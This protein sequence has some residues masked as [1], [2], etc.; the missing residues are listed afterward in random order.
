MS[1]KRIIG[2]KAFVI[3]WSSSAISISG[4]IIFTIAISW[5]VI[6]LTK[7]ILWVSLLL[8]ATL[9]PYAFLLPF[10]GTVVDRKNKKRVVLYSYISQGIIVLTVSFIYLMGK[11]IVPIVILLIFA[12][13]MFAPFISTAS[14]ALY[15]RLLQRE[16]L[17]S[18]NSLSFLSTNVL[19]VSSFG[20]GGLIIALFG[21][22]VPIYYDVGTFLIAT[23]IFSALH[24][25]DGFLDSSS[26]KRKYSSHLI[27]GVSWLF[28]NRMIRELLMVNITLTYFGGIFETLLLGYSY[29]IIGH[30]AYFYGTILAVL[31]LGS[32]LSSFFLGTRNINKVP[33]L[34]ALSNVPALGIGMLLLG[35]VYS[36]WTSLT[37]VFAIGFAIPLSVITTSALLQSTPDKEMVGVVNGSFYSLQALAPVCGTLSIGFLS[38]FFEVANLLIYSG[39]IMMVMS[40]VFYLLLQPLRRAQI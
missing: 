38:Q 28:K 11:F 40:G 2:N 34:L 1:Y 17:A 21:P 20:I 35:F 23:L 12:L 16:D 8:F 7:S 4:D 18:A 30:E 26:T 9:L 33:G 15:P 39:L 6:D 10:A 27:K 19:Q 29:N 25:D 31:T 5:T 22:T 36:F 3:L 13:N 32:A 14:D 24:I 37:I